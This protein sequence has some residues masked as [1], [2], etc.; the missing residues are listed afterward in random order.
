[1]SLKQGNVRRWGLSA[2]KQVLIFGF[3]TDEEPFDFV[4]AVPQGKA[5][6]TEW[7]GQWGF[8][9]CPGVEYANPWGHLCRSVARPPSG[10]LHPFL[11]KMS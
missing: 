5:R 2:L 8:A 10:V 1:M 9:G 11:C 3:Q 7:K 6:T 4:S